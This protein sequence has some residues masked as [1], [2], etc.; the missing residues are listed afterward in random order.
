[1]AP[2]RKKPRT[3]R[4][5][6]GSVASGRSRNSRRSKTSTKTKTRSTRRSGRKL[7]RDVQ[8]MRELSVF[9]N[10]FSVATSSPRIPDGKVESSIGIKSQGRLEIKPSWV[11]EDASDGITHLFIY[12]GLGS[13]LIV[14]KHTG[15]GLRQYEVV[16]YKDHGHIE[17]SN[18]GSG[19]TNLNRTFENIDHISKWR[20]V[21]QGV[22][23]ECVN[24]DDFNDGWFEA[25]RL[26]EPID[27]ENWMICLSNNST[28]WD[29]NTVVAPAIRYLDG[30][31]KTRNLVDEPSYTMGRLKD[32]HNLEFH[33]Q[34]TNNDPDFNKMSQNTLLYQTVDTLN[35]D[36][37][38]SSVNAPHYYAY[39][40]GG[41]P[42]CR[43]LVNDYIDRNHDCVYVRIHGRTDG[44]TRILAHVVSNQELK[45]SGD[46]RESKYE[47]KTTKSATVPE[48]I[49]FKRAASSAGTSLSPDYA[50]MAYV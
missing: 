42:E 14:Y 18:L 31:L 50:S 26:S 49:S 36:Q 22:K 6:G 24:N 23:L 15:E 5:T 47:S 3:K 20:L 37:A 27:E 13:G 40:R 44:E 32:I 29:T 21:S 43:N 46:Q 8:A 4:R 45:F 11:G 16:G 41:K 17:S 19:T 38:I 7:V 28:D 33:L 9:R 12:P 25:V 39:M 1:M 35:P 30:D 10:P 2:V 48:N 34:P